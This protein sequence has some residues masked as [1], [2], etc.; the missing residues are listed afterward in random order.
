MSQPA[1]TTLIVTYNSGNEILNLLDDLHSY[2]SDRNVIVIDNASSDET[3]TVL[4]EH[5]PQIQ[6]IQNSTNVGYAKA[7]NQGFDLCNT[8]YVLLLNPDIRIDSPRLFT[9]M[10]KCLKVSRQIA[11]VAPLQFK[12]EGGNQYLNFT[13][14]YMTRNTFK[15]YVSFLL[16]DKQGSTNPIPVTFLN[17]GCL[18][19][20]RSAFEHVGRLN[21]KYFLYGEE[22]DLFLKF[23]R[24]GFDCYLLSHVAVTHYRERSLMTRPLLQRLQIRLQAAWNVIDAL[25]NGWAS[26]L[27]HRRAV[28]KTPALNGKQRTS[29][30][31]RISDHLS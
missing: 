10:E 30:R 31:K 13:W 27:L 8:E 21:E 23:K 5:F 28:K 18:L 3:V 17:A 1:F 11:A 29:Y 2:A 12:N 20:R 25:I 15:L 26:I 4:Q 6:L 16:Q 24:Y 7:V 19:I 22:P 9:E 14:S